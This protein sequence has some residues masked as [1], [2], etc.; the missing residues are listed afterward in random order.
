MPDPN[1]F[2]G[3]TDEERNRKKYDLP[4]TEEQYSD[5]MSRHGT[6]A[7]TAQDAEV[8]RRW[9]KSDRSQPANQEPS[10]AAP[11]LDQIDVT[12]LDSKEPEFVDGEPASTSRKWRN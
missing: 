7:W 2:D 1:A 11:D 6:D 8:Q 5:A 10:P 3:L 12:A 9:D 4:P